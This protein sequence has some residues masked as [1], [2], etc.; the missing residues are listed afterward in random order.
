VRRYIYLHG[1]R[2]AAEM[3]KAERGFSHYARG[4]AQRDGVHA[5]AGSV[6]VAL[7]VQGGPA[8]GFS[9]AGRGDTR[10][11]AGAATDGIDPR[12]SARPARRRFSG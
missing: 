6:G 2:N 4:G 11:E 1:K 3:G 5:V 10:K 12:R 8:P 9:L 7:F